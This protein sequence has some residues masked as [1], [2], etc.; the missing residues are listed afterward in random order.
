MSTFRFIIA[1]GHG[2]LHR[3]RSAA[4][5]PHPLVSGIFDQDSWRLTAMNGSE[6]RGEIGVQLGEMTIRH[7]LLLTAAF[8][9]A[10]AGAAFL[11]LLGTFIIF[12]STI[13]ALVPVHRPPAAP[14]VYDRF[15]FSS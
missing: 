7:W 14:P 12:N 4:P 10:L 9:L 5:Y 8:L 3:S 15:E 2:R 13:P 6:S 11:A 1:S